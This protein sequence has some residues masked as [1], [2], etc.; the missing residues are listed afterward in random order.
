MR[1]QRKTF[2]VNLLLEHAPV[3]VVGGGRVGL[4]K[5]RALLEAGAEVHLVCPEPLEDFAS[6]PVTMQRRTFQ[7][8]DVQGMRLVFACTNEKRVNGA[9]LEAA[10]AAGI[11]C[12]C[13]DGH[14]AEGDFIVPALLRTPDL[15]IAVSSNGRS[16]RTAKETR[17]VLA[18]ALRAPGELCIVGMDPLPDARDLA[19]L[20]GLYG[21]AKLTT[22]HRSELLLWASPELLERAWLRGA[23][24]WRGEEARKHLAFLL[25]GLRSK[26]VGEIHIV[27]QVRDAM[28]QA[29]EAGTAN[30]ALLEAY[31]EALAQSRALREAVA[32]LMPAIEV[33]DLAL[34][35][36]TGRIVVAGTGRLAQAAIAKAHA[37]GLEVSVLY[38]VHPLEGEA[39]TP[40]AD[41]RKVLGGAT[42]FISA[43]AVK[44]PFFKA[45]ELAL[46]A[47][48]LGAPRNIE[49]DEGVR[50]LDDLRGDYLRRTGALE[51]IMQAA[52]KAWQEMTR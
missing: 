8:A 40:L 17:D 15:L 45:S 48:D 41:W 19:L 21:W 6:L 33:E 42:R 49:G 43:L 5:T 16:C 3:L 44:S 1:P 50:D 35:G 27:G 12:C 9:V 34:E 23:Y 30:G 37:R 4:R 32:P 39:C 10:R 28:E 14:W 22:C 31:A 7:P 18:R 38:H 52:E 29:R 24:A 46:P 13:A 51:P 36:A 26:M 47:C 20:S 25:A 11:P 2:P